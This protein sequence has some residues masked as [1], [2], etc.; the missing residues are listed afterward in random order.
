MALWCRDFQTVDVARSTVPH[1]VTIVLPYYENRIFLKR[2]ID[3]WRAF[4]YDL[5]Q[6]LSAII[7]DD[8]SPEPAV[9]PSAPPF[10]IR[11]F[12]IEV[13]VRWNWL[14]ARN[15]GMNHA[16]KGWCFLSD[17]D[18]VL[19]EETAKAMVYGVL[20][21]R[22]AYAFQRREHTGEPAAPHS[23]TFFLT[24]E[25][26][27]KTGGYDEAL[28]GHYGTDGEF[29]RR[30]AKVAPIKVA[31]ETVERWEYVDDSSTTR[32]QRKQPED[33]AVARIV[34]RRGPGW[35]PQVLSFPYHE[36]DRKEGA[37]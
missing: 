30:L 31:T 23:A 7:V 13:D 35:K 3:R 19:P 14:A 26:F 20:D 15:V 17:M 24:R 32:Y 5:R 1:H 6:H 37:A 21:S 34:A 27:W 25:T 8:G 22:N 10:P 36:V 18:H 12:R 28:S 9:L 16:P 33:A 29:R 11:L 2:Q 4:N